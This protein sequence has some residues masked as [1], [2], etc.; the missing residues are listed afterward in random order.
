MKIQR[1]RLYRDDGAPVAF[2]ASPNS[3]KDLQY[4]YLVIHYTAGRSA[5]ASIR[6]LT[7][8]AARASAHVVIAR[9]GSVTQLVAFNRVAWHAGRSSWLNRTGL[10]HYSLGIELDNAGPLQ[11][12]GERWRAWFGDEYDHTQVIEAVHKHE[13]QPRG[14]HVYTP[15]QIE[16]AL[17][18][19]SLL[20][21]R[22][23]LRDVLGHEDISPGRKLDPGPAFPLQSFRSRLMGR[24]ENDEPQCKTTANLNIRVGPGTQHPTVPGSPLPVGTPVVVLSEQGTW[25]FVDV[26]QEIHGVMDMQGW[27]HGRYLQPVDRPE[28]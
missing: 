17:E 25:R 6:W 3:G 13:N 5:E 20:V 11:R 16:A 9:D 8:P 27:V 22:Y 23:R 10:N 12:H 14:W 21:R 1:H 24:A 28:P 19:S 2:T 7:N 15:A 18:V 4:E 26:P